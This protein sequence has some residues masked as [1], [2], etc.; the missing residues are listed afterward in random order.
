MQRILPREHVKDRIV[1]ITIARTHGGDATVFPSTGAVLGFQLSGRVQSG[2][3]LLSQAGVTGI[4]TGARRYGYLGP[5]TSIL[6]RFTPQGAACL[7]VPAHELSNRSVALEEL[8]PR[9][10]SFVERLMDAPGTDAGAALVEELIAGLPWRE[11][12]L[13]A[14]ALGALEAGRG[15]GDVARKTGLSERQLERRFLAR[16]GI[17]PKRYAMLHRF[18]RALDLMKRSTSLTETALDAG[19]YDQ[20]HF[21][22]EVRRLTGAPPGR[23]AAEMSDLSNRA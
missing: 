10:R 14:F 7:G 20:S 21:I 3:A 22:R 8:F 15:V 18:E 16:V 12:P 19:Y 5:T 11:D 1:S 13:V 4:Q 6:V 2:A 9:G 23:L 17:P